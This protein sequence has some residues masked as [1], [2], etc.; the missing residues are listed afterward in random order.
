MRNR[1]RLAL[2]ALS[3]LAVG[4]V[5][6]TRALI[7]RADPQTNVEYVTNSDVQKMTIWTVDRSGGA[8]KVT[9]AATYGIE[10]DAGWEALTGAKQV[11]FTAKLSATVVQAE[12]ASAAKTSK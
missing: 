3:M 4:Y 9:A 11:P 8:P 6:G 10:E 2:L 5:V 1:F 7:V 12:K